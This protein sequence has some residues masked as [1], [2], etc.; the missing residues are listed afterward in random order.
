MKIKNYLSYLCIILVLTISY[1]NAKL[2]ENDRYV[3]ICEESNLCY[4]IYRDGHQT[5]QLKTCKEPSRPQRQ[6]PF[7]NATCYTCSNNIC[8]K[9][10][11]YNN[12]YFYTIYGISK[13]DRLFFVTDK[14]YCFPAKM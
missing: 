5:V 1:V 9:T 10:E 6:M 7:L 8:N 3:L 12:K 13:T 11:Y 14:G 2:C 4:K